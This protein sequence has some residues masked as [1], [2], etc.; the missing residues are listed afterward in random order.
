M[1]WLLYGANGYT[2]RLVA[3]LAASRGHKPILAGRSADKVRPLADKLGLPWR[4]FALEDTAA[5]DEALRGVPLV[6]H[7]AGPFSQTSRPMVDACLRAGAHYLDVTGEIDVFEAVHARDAEAKARGVTLIP[8]VGFDVV[9]SDCLAALLHRALPTA[10]ELELA[11]AA[12]GGGRGGLSSAGTLKTSLEG[13]GKGGRVR[14]GGRIVE[15]PLAHDA[16]EIEF[17]DKRRYCM[18]IPWGDVSTAYRSTGIPDIT[19]YMASSRR[20]V[21]SARMMRWFAP[22]LRFK[23][24]LRFLQGRIAARVTGPSEESRKSGKVQLWGRATDGQ[25]TVE[26]RM[27]TPEGYQFT[28]EATLQSAERVLAGQAPKGALTPSRAFGPDYAASLPGVSV[29]I[30]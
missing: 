7:C 18:T 14:R 3:E 15:V 27:T 22:A 23:P 20:A 25:K 4:A 24:L 17:A 19:V 26:G 16:K 10:R 5:L 21:R 29:T 30:R 9:P 12:G 28:A 11:F 2:G 13:M 8:G 1:S 6:V